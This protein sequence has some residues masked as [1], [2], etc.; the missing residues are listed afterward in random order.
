MQ[1]SDCRLSTSLVKYLGFFP[2]ESWPA[3]TN[4]WIQM[5]ECY[6][7]PWD[8]LTICSLFPWVGHQAAIFTTSSPA[9]GIP[10]YYVLKNVPFG[11]SSVS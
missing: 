6:Q 9:L 5:S 3:R 2:R 1:L 8:W 7:G 4:H 11:D 10:F